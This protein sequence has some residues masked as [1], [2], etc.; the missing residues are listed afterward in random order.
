[1]I[2][3]IYV[4]N[5]F[6]LQALLR[7]SNFMGITAK[8]GVTLGAFDIKYK[9][10][11]SVKGQVLED[12]VAEFSPE[13]MV[14]CGVQQI[15]TRPWRIYMDGV[16]NTRRSGIEVMLESPKGIRMEHSLQLAFQA[17]N[18]EAKYETLLIGF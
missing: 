9:L 2:Y 13:I 7:K 14:V 6:P 5:E 8:W 12:F 15:S 1:M 4:L 11:N 18:N 16:L 17:S 3:T 10:R